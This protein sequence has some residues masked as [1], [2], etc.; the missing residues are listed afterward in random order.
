MTLRLIPHALLV[1]FLCLLTACSALSKRSQPQPGP[2]IVK[3]IPPKPGTPINPPDLVCYFEAQSSNLLRQARLNTNLLREPRPATCK[4]KLAPAPTR[5][6][7]PDEIAST[8]EMSVAVIGGMAR[9]RGTPRL[10]PTAS[11]FFLT[12]SGVLVTCWHVIKSDKLIGLTVMTRDGRVCPV[13]KVLA[14]N[15]NSDLAILQVEGSGFSPLPIATFARRGSPV[16]VLGHPFPWYYMLTS[17]IVSGYYNLTQEQNEMR[18]LYITADFAAGSSGAPVLNQ[19]GAVVG[20]AQFRQD[21]GLP[22]NPLML[23]K[24]CIPSSAL[25]SMIKTE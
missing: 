18:F 24:G 6:L 14:V 5:V 25:L 8:V 9:I 10:T 13:T 12:E 15:T 4:L 22:G 21:I 3:P 2:F 23:I 11:G 16:W 20:V 1:A 19:S 17:G 7:A